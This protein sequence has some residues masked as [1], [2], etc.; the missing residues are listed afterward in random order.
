[1]IWDSLDVN[2]LKQQLDKLTNINI[3]LSELRDAI[4]GDDN[5]TLT[6]IYNKLGSIAGSVEISN[7]PSWFTSSTK[8]IDD[9]VSDLN[10]LTNALLSVGSDK[11]LV[12]LTEA[13]P[14]G[15]NV[16]GRIKI[17]DGTNL[18]S[19]VQG[20]LAG[21]S[22]YMIPIAPDLTAMFAS[23]MA[24]TEQEVTVTTTEDSSSF[25]PPLKMTLLCN[26]GDVDITIKL[27]GGST[28]KKIPAHGCKAIVM[29][30]IS[31]ISYSVASGSSTLRIEGYW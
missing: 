18:L 11:L 19:L 16:I 8:T 23:G 7:L 26:E 5:R 17:T 15:D 4:R 20:E 6:D 14:A 9:I 25:S 12:S 2:Y 24:Y 28:T 13:L 30:K 10:K 3:S 31:S 27:N 22:Y 21:I 29:W 1:M